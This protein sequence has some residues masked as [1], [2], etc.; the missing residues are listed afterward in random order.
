MPTNK[1][2]LSTYVKNENHQKFNI[3]AEKEHRTASQQLALLV[4]N[5]IKEYENKNGTINMQQINN[6]GTI[7]NIGNINTQNINSK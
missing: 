4:D 6:E 2:K 3:I 5:F 1:P 7:H